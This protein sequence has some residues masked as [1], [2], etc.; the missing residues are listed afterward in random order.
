MQTINRVVLMLTLLT[1]GCYQ[2]E[3]ELR[4]CVVWCECSMD[5]VEGT[6]EWDVCMEDCAE[7]VAESDEACRK[8]FAAFNRCIHNHDCDPIPCGPQVDRFV[9]SCRIWG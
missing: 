3:A 6:E 2:Q 4:P 9:E 8:A 7:F 5:A 1:F